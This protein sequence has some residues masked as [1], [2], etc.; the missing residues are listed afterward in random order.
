MSRVRWWILIVGPFAI[1]AASFALAQWL[2]TEPSGPPERNQFLIGEADAADATDRRSSD[3]RLAAACRETADQLVPRLGPECSTIV[4]PPFVLA[5]DMPDDELDAWHRETIT[6]A[7]RAMTR[8]MLDTLPDRPITV[9]LL[10]GESSYNH[11]AEK[12]FGDRGVSIYGYY[13]PGLRMLVL[14][15]GTGGGTLVHELTHALVEFDFP[16]IPDWFNEGLASLHEQCRFRETE[17][18]P[19][20]VGL[21]NWRLTGLQKAIR[22]G[23]VGSLEALFAGH[24]FRGPQQGLNYAQ[25]R[26][27]C[28]Y[29]ERQGR[30]AEFYRQFRD[31]CDTDPHGTAALA[32]VIPDFSW[33]S[34]DHGFQHWVLGL[35]YHDSRAPEAAQA[36]ARD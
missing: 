33:G 19:T 18:G 23:Q 32:G 2:R 16:K 7:M 17:D 9:L 5:G 34:F 3:E 21:E 36:N 15:I 29:L 25:A 24:D 30:L 27:F 13:K 28:L 31:S 11:Y 12:L 6:T 10:S 14:N 22:A 26:Y 8:T 20:I 4:R 1:L 35:E